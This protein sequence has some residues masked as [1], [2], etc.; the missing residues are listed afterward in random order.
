MISYKKRAVEG[1]RN[2]VKKEINHTSTLFAMGDSRKKPYH[3][4]DGFLE[5][6][7]QRGG[8][9]GSLNWKSQGRGEY[10]R[11]KF[12]RPKALGWG[13]GGTGGSGWNFEKGQPRVYSLKTLI[14][15]TLII[16]SQIKH[17]DCRSRQAKTK[18][19]VRCTSSSRGLN[20]TKHPFFHEN[21]LLNRPFALRGHVTS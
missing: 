21:N 17:N 18:Q 6:R 8:G 16:S 10:L 20:A 7:G 11:L 3:Y 2:L 5:F 4:T 9:G 15:W 13:G 19:N 14:L 12:R 1:Y